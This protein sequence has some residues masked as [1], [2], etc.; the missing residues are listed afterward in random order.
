MSSQPIS[1]FGRSTGRF[2]TMAEPEQR[3]PPPDNSVLLEWSTNG[4]E[5]NYAFDRF[6]PD[7]PDPAAIAVIVRG[8][9]CVSVVVLESDFRDED[10]RLTYTA[11]PSTEPQRPHSLS[12]ADCRSNDANRLYL[13]K[14]L[15]RCRRCWLKA[16]G[17][18]VADATTP[19]PNKDS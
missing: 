8:P 7:K 11:G 18:T 17:V 14:R 1:R 19:T 10:G 5:T 6:P 16:L 4:N 13:H 3:E 9:Q 2:V 15:W 12:C